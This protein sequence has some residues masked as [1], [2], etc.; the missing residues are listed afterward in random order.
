[1]PTIRAVLH[2]RI[3]AA[4]SEKLFCCTPLECGDARRAAADGNPSAMEECALCA[5]WCGA[6]A[7]CLSADWHI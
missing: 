3:G 4:H 7:G 5:A 6:A 2:L 1:M